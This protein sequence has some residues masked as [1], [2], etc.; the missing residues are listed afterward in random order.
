MDVRSYEMKYLDKSYFVKTAA[1]LDRFDW[2]RT[3]RRIAYR[4]K[5]T[6]DGTHWV[7]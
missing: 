6:G 2:N 3:K 4:E 7:L 5:I 1:E